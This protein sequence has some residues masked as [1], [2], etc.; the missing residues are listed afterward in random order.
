MGYGKVW[1]RPGAVACCCHSIYVMARF[2]TRR[3]A[4]E[5]SKRIMADTL[6]PTER[7]ARMALVR[8]RDTSP[9]RK[10][11]AIVRSLG[12]RYTLNNRSLPGT[13]DLAFPN[14]QKVIFVHGCFWHRHPNRRCKLA[15]L[16]KSRLEFWLPKL[17]ENRARDLRTQRA[18]NRLDW[19]YIVI[20]ECQLSH[21]DRIEARIR[22]FLGQ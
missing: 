9:E 2:D 19:R 14:V 3:I 11:R 12:Y 17:L 8:A 13:P 21:P 20:W 7:S 6:T 18:L 22:K 1:K 4:C 10:V 16:P 5:T 15:R